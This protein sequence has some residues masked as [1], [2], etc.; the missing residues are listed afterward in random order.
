MKITIEVWGK[1]CEAFL[2]KI[3]EEQLDTLSDGGVEDDQMSVKEIEEVLEID[4]ITD[5]DNIST[6]VYPDSFTIRVLN[7]DESV[8]WESDDNFEFSEYEDQYLYNDDKY[9]MIQ[10]YQ[11]GHFFTYKL[12]IDGEF[13]PSL[14]IA[15]NTEL[16]DGVAEIITGVKYGE[17]EIEWEDF[18]DTTSKGFYFSLSY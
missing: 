3:T 17:T 2:H 11:K 1:G 16:L 8:L 12:E 10:D 18:G 9:L 7:E 13:D 5:T 6:G 4:S 15:T 14:L